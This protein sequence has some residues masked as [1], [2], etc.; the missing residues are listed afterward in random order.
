MTETERLIREEMQKLRDFKW[1]ATLD[2]RWHGLASVDT[3]SHF[4]RCSNRTA[5]QYAKKLVACGFLEE[6]KKPGHRHYTYR[7]R[8]AGGQ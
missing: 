2:E 3:I 6:V 8:N 7:V 4:G 5:R 1:D